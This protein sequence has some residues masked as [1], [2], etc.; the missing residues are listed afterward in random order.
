[1][2]SSIRVPTH[3]P[4]IRPPAP[5]TEEEGADRF[6]GREC[7]V[8]NSS[9]RP[10]LNDTVCSHCRFYLTSRCPHIEEFLDDV[11]DLSPE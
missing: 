6:V 2:R 5:R 10:N 11:E 3:L 1:M 8:F 7:Y 4:S 9:L